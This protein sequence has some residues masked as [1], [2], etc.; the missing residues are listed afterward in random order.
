MLRGVP[1]SADTDA[2]ICP[3]TPR[4]LRAKRDALVMDLQRMRASQATADAA[5]PQPEASDSQVAED[6]GADSLALAM[7]SVAL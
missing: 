4:Q 3:A 1:A 6:S 5:A 2:R 7:G